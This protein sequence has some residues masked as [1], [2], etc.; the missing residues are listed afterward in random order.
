MSDTRRESGPGPFRR[1]VTGSGDT[2]GDR[3]SRPSERRVATDPDAYRSP[4]PE[5]DMGAGD[6]DAL[7]TVPPEALVQDRKRRWTWR[8]LLAGLGIGATALVAG[9]VDSAIAAAGEGSVVGMLAAASAVLL[10][11]AL[12]GLVAGEIISLSRLR[13]RGQTRVLVEQ[14]TS[15][16]D[17][18]QS[19]KA[20]AA[21]IVIHEGRPA[22]AWALARYREE[23]A[24]VPDAADKLVLYERLVMGPL[25]EACVA[26]IRTVARRAA[27]LT[28][29]APNPILDAVF[30]LWLNLSVVRRVARV[31]G[32][33]PGAAASW[34]LLRRT[35]LAMIAAGGMEAIGDMAPAVAGGLVRTVARRVGEGAIN[36]LLTIRIGVAAL[37]ACR[38]MPFAAR[39]R[40]SVTGLARQ[41]VGG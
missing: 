16:R 12:A 26:E 18:V 20:L 38:P 28:A 11:L 6:S 7:A 21:L 13:S 31:Q 30:V 35:F 29:F 33:R 1:P 22:L 15:T 32:L 39:E 19:E 14:A 36:G 23:S 41:V 25:D 24:D 34:A 5:P 2:A 9:L 4:E 10:G 40:P 8:L 27:V 3:E 17:A 37:E